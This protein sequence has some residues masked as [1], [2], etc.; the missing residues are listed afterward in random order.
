MPD[1][2]ISLKNVSAGYGKYKAGKAPEEALVL[3][4][5]SFEITQG[6]SVCLLGQNGCGKTT[7]LRVIAGMLPA[8]GEVLVDGRNI[9]ELRRKE[10]ASYMSF[11]SQMT[12]VYYSYSVFE[13]VM[14][15]RYVHGSSFFSGTASEDR[16]IVEETLENLGLQ[17]LAD[18]Q[19]T[20]LSGG[21]IQRV[22]LARC[23]A[24][25]SPVMILDEPM[26]YLDM[27]IQS[28]FMEY[29][30][31]WREKPVKMDGGKVY[32]PTMIGVFHD[33]YLTSCLAD[34]VALIADGR[35]LA[36]GRKKDMLTEELL[37]KTYCFDVVGYLRKFRSVFSCNPGI[38]DVY[39]MT[40]G[41]S[42]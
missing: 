9:K 41:D 7:L 4:D 28:E 13:T 18:R 19:I 31:R 32:R 35:L 30:F 37:E 38:G 16:E 1:R 27:K 26:N 36:F 6:S 15:G 23:I 40:G 2:M 39:T 42:G 34:E 20:T 8:R 3:K 14:H 25:E 17:D 22:M 5:L 21:Q 29:L 12:R 11:L 10:I 33:I 24:Q